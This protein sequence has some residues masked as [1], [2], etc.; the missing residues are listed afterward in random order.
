MFT[1]YKPGLALDIAVT[2]IVPHS[3]KAGWCMKYLINKSIIKP[4]AT[5]VAGYL[6]LEAVVLS[7]IV[8][9]VAAALGIIKEKRGGLSSDILTL[10]V[11]RR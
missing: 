3:R 8:G 1:S 9:E 11:C 4:K 7:A 5:M 10:H 6:V 2:C